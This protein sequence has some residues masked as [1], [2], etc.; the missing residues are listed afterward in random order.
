MTLDSLFLSFPIF[1]LGFESSFSTTKKKSYI[2]CTPHILLSSFCYN[3]Y[4]EIVVGIMSEKEF[5]K[6]KLKL[7]LKKKRKKKEWE[8]EKHIPK[9]GT[10]CVF[11]LRDLYSR[12]T[13]LSPNQPYVTLGLQWVALLTLVKFSN[14]PS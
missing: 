8:R 1:S 13:L 3:I 7:K 4:I 12:W 14:I 5:H 10:L 6:K 11:T 9:K 2:I